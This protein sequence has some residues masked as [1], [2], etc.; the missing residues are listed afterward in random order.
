LGEW[1]SVVIKVSPDGEH[2]IKLAADGTYSET[3]ASPREHHAVSG[4]FRIRTADMPFSSTKTMK[5]TIIDMF[6]N[7]IDGKAATAE[8]SKTPRSYFYNNLN[9]KEALF[10]FMEEVLARPDEVAS[11]KVAIASHRPPTQK[12]TVTTPRDQMIGHEWNPVWTSG[13]AAVPRL[14]ATVAL[15]RSAPG[16]PNALVTDGADGRHVFDLDG[17]QL[18]VSG[19]GFQQFVI[20]LKRPDNDVLAEHSTW[21]QSVRVRSLDGTLLWEHS[22]PSGVDSAC[23]VDLGAGKPQGLAI[24]YNG[25]GGAVMLDSEGKVVWELK[26]LGNAWNMAQF[27]WAKGM[28]AGVLIAENNVLFVNAAGK[29]IHKVDADAGA[30]CGADLNGS[31]RDVA[32]TL[33]TTVVS[34]SKLSCYDTSGKQLWSVATSGRYSVLNQPFVVGRFFGGGAVIGIADRG[35]QVQFFDAGGHSKGV[36]VLGTGIIGACVI[37]GDKQDDLAIRTLQGLTRYHWSGGSGQS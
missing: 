29:V 28:P 1:D 16:A 36:W 12:P 19:Q 20:G 17:Q 30:V 6:A 27:H 35:G 34:G 2:V 14:E 10:S 11:A 13:P 9:G 3:F 25:G 18:S 31:G 26:D 8:E 7:E 24:S 21:D 22:N 32:L 4:T 15:V 33:G 23:A 5:M 37:P